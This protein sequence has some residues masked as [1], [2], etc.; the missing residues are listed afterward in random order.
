MTNQ[1]NLQKLINEKNEAAHKMMFI[2]ELILENFEITTK[3]GIKD[4]LEPLVTE[5]K[6]RSKR[7]RKEKEK[8]L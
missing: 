3:E 4:L 1:Q 2:A 8:M 7:V 6:E 5:Y